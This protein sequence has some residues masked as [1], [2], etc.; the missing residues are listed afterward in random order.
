M[1]KAII[2]DFAGVLTSSKCFPKIAENLWKQYNI[3][4]KLIM[5]SLYDSEKDYILGKETTESFWKNS[6]E[7]LDISFEDFIFHFQNWYI[8]DEALLSFIKKLKQEY[9][10]VL[11]SDNFEIIS[12][13]LKKDPKLVEL[14]DTMIF[15]NDIGYNKTQKEAF[16]YG[17]HKIDLNASECIFTDDKQ[18]NLVAPNALGIQVILYTSFEDF[19]SKLENYL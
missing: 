5:E 10:I 11:H 8:L 2:F 1:I 13:K 7:K 12:S 18:K 14:F 19:K 3:D 15:S 16:E 17:L 6:C 9:T 4:K